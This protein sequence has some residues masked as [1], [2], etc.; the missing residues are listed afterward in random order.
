[1]FMAC[2]PPACRRLLEAVRP[3][4]AVVGMLTAVLGAT[5]ATAQE[6]P[7]VNV[8]FAFSDPAVTG[9]YPTAAELAAA[10]QALSSRLAQLFE[11][12][13]TYWPTRAG[14]RAQYP[15]L[16]MRLRPDGSRWF[17][18]VELLPVADQPASYSQQVDVYAAGEI[19][20]LGGFPPRGRLPER[21]ESKLAAFYSNTAAQNE[22]RLKLADGAPL[23]A[24]AY[25]AS[26]TGSCV[27]VLPL[28]WK[29]YCSLATSVFALEY[30]RSDGSRVV[31]L[32]QGV[33]EPRMFPP[34]APQFL[35][36]T[37]QPKR[38]LTGGSEDDI[39]AHLADLG[40]LTPRFFRLKQLTTDLSAC[41][42][43]AGMPPAVV[44]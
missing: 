29:R 14:D 33:G 13:V 30:G 35:G 21:I 41:M 22:L 39:A 6:A 9:L 37:V 18:L 24:A 42:D 16:L 44:R 25:V 2:R 17:V 3:R 19:S 43:V 40:S 20:A 4:V 27:A 7:A 38:W 34:D 31:V 36:L 26:T 23:G 15:Q 32:G 5:P 12:S 28:S 1:R 10:A 11:R 8:Q